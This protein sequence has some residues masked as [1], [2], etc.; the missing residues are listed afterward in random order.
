MDFYESIV[1]A[2]TEI[3]DTMTGL[4]VEAAPP[5]SQSLG[6]FENSVSGI[7]GLSGDLQGMLCVHC[8]DQVA[9]AITTALLGGEGGKDE[10][11]D[12]IGELANMVSGSVKIA[13]AKDGKTVQLS[14]PTA[15]AG[16]EY[17]MRSVNQEEQMA[18]PFGLAEGTFIV[19]LRYRWIA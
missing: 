6:S 5:S 3:F 13:L 2:I 9:M 8:P 16:K 18:V 15:V 17:S 7:L 10:I 12:A 4:A 1:H 19:E 14:L 11:R